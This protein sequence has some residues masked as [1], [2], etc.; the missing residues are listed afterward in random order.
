MPR[1]GIEEEQ[2]S[3][4]PRAPRE[5]NGR[6]SDAPLG[7]E[8]FCHGHRGPHPL[9]RTCPRLISRWASLRDEK[10]VALPNASAI[11]SPSFAPPALLRGQFT[12]FFLRFLAFFAA[13]P[14]P[15]PGLT[16][17]SPPGSGNTRRSSAHTPS[18][19]PPSAPCESHPAAS[20]A[21]STPS[22]GSPSP[23]RGCS[24]WPRSDCSPPG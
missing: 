7:H 1:R 14:V 13:N 18:A 5:A 8:G 10:R 22:R 21:A 4:T 3:T 20:P 12:F 23:P 11:P 19:R 9:A 17:S 15:A 24:S 2:P 16:Y 6:F